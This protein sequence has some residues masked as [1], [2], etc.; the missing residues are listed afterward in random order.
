MVAA[1]PAQPLQI[2]LDLRSHRTAKLGPTNA[3]AGIR[4]CLTYAD[5]PRAR[6][7]DYRLARHS[8]PTAYS[9]PRAGLRSRPAYAY[10]RC[11]RGS[12]TPAPAQR[13]G[14]HAPRQRLRALQPL[15][16][17]PHR[18][19]VSLTTTFHCRRSPCL[20]S[21]RLSLT[22]DVSDSPI[23][24]LRLLEIYNVETSTMNDDYLHVLQD[25]IALQLKATFGLCNRFKFRLL[26]SRFIPLH[27]RANG[28][29]ASFRKPAME[30]LIRQTLQN[31]LDICSPTSVSILIQFKTPGLRIPRRLHE[32]LC[33]PPKIGGEKGTTTM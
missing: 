24:E 27:C 9:G 22:V 10:S 1:L 33:I 14:G 15:L 23:A 2:C 7:C 26:G 6:Q 30:R 29:R 8:P 25:Y 18:Q 17:T 32:S 4:S 16:P 28:D 11:D 21:T 20:S 5:T 19:S 12:A 13:T 3:Q 31:R